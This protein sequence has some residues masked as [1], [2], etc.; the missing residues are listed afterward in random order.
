MARQDPLPTVDP[1]ADP[2]GDPPPVAG[3][4]LAAGTSSRFGDENKLLADVDGHPLVRHAAESLLAAE[5]DPIVAVV[6]Y[7]AARVAAAL[8]GLPIEIVENPSYDEGQAASVRVGLRA[9]RDRADAVVFALGDMPAVSPGAVA[10][11]VSSYAAGGGTA[12]AA[13]HDGRRG[14]PVLFGSRYFDALGAV[15]GDTGARDVLLE[16]DD[17]ALVETGDPGVCRDVDSRSDL[18]RLRGCE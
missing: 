9:V 12:L 5:L 18:D 16:S 11:L 3:V 14:N 13:A 1:P 10:A 17:A 15:D 4:L 6:G 7:E 8:D 2:D